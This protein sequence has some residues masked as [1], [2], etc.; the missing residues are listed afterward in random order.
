MWNPEQYARFEKERALPFHDL[1]ALV[2]RRTQ[3]R[4]VDLG[5]GTGAL[6]RQL[7]D[8]LDA[9]ETLGIDS[10]AEM[11]AKA[12]VHASH[13]LRFERCDIE[14]FAA[15]DLDLLFSNAA[16]HWIPDHERLFPKLISCLGS[17]GQLAVQI[18]WNDDHPSH[19]IAREVAAA[20][21][22]APQRAVILPPER[23]SSILHSAGMTRQHVRMQVYGHLLPSAADVVEWVKG[24]TLTEY[25]NPLEPDRYEEFVDEYSRRLMAEIGEGENY[26]YTFKRVLIWGTR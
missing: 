8:A 15:T 19:R 5:C 23:Y 10:S 7:H 17:R 20:F 26:F 16:L 1:V 14:G 2:E 3:M 22:L 4:V 13:S 9:S 12:N 25:R 18:P 24:S 21:G 6:T 11:L